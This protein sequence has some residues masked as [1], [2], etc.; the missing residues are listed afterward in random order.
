MRRSG[1]LAVTLLATRAL[2]APALPPAWTHAASGPAHLAVAFQSPPGIAAPAW[3]R[4]TDASGRAITFVA[5]TTP[6]C[7]R[8]NVYAVGSVTLNGQTSPRVFAFARRTG[9]PLWSAV[10]DAPYS[11]SWSS[12]A[13]DEGNGIVVVA[14]GTH[15][16]CFDLVSGSPRWTVALDAP[17]VNA[18]PTIATDLP[19]ANRVFITDY[20]GFGNGGQ[21]YCINTSPRLGTSNPHD[22][23]DLLWRAPLGGTSGNTTAEYAG[24]VFVATVGDFGAAPGQILCFDARAQTSPDPL[25]TADNPAGQGFFGGLCVAPAT[26][27]WP[28]AVYAASYA[29]SGGLTSANLLK[30]DAASGVMRWSV[31]CNRTASTPVPF[32]LAG[33]HR[34]LLAGGI[35]GYGSAPGL[36]LF[37]D[38]G[39]SASPLWSTVT[40]TWVDANH[41]SRIDSGEYTPV[42][43]WQSQPAV[44]IAGSSAWAFAPTPGAGAQTNAPPAALN[45]LNLSAAPNSPSFWSASTSGLG[46]AVALAGSNVYSLGTA[47]LS[48]F[49]TPPP[50]C[51]VTGNGIVDIDDLYA[52]EQGRGNRDVNG[53]GVVDETDRQLL[54]GELRQGEFDETR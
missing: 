7:S 53:D 18:S 33:Q 32:T 14:S 48:A 38:L 8:L 19:L 35:A 39:T 26:V 10:V 40:S 3:T 22:P 36:E 2:G 46:G 16:R 47:G 6:V 12:P 21:L 5:N 13:V 41:N 20:D 1:V 28:A 49:G 27:G 44:C 23:G 29:F 51:D 30:L 54:I 25:W 17:V 50:D 31:P 4:S 24:R 9:L 11:D 37:A 45:L 34:V 43:G 52:W 15:V 42:G